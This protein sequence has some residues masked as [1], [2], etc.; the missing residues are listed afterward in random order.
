V[1]ETDSQ[2]P[3]PH[4]AIEAR[5]SLRERGG[6]GRAEESEPE[7]ELELVHE[8]RR[9]RHEA[10]VPTGGGERRE[11]RGGCNAARQHR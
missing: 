3:P 7:G 5:V 10:A 9:G 2:S 6:D 4:G 11:F 8:V 1:A